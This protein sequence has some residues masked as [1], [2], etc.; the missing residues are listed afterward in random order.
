MLPRVPAGLS[1][2]T[3]WRDGIIGMPTPSARSMQLRWLQFLV[4]VL[5]LIGALVLIGLGITGHAVPAGSVNVWLIVAGGFVI[6]VDLLVM[7]SFPSATRT[8]LAIADQANGLRELRTALG[9]LQRIL[10]SIEENTRLSDTAKSVAHREQELEAL[11]TA[12]HDDYRAE[13]WEAALNLIDD[14]ERRFGT[15]EE[16]ERLREELDVARSQAIE[17]KLNDAIGNVE[18][19]FQVYAWEKAQQEIDRLILAL[20]EHA[21]VVALQDRMATLKVTHKKELLGAWEEAVRRSDTDHAIDVLKELDQYLSR[22]EAQ[23]L[24]SSARNVFKEKLLQMGVQFRFAVTE[25]RWQD[26]LS[27]GLDIVREF[28]N[29]R[30]ASEV[31]DA[32]DTLRERA[33][34]VPA[35]NAEAVQ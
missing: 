10:E 15:R 17:S 23:A 16:A 30:M 18:T 19:H 27:V 31:R 22:A 2:D 12:I 5:A 26:A 20:P 33:R 6:F 24:Q 13:A 1:L 11:R 14:M 7:T 29:A 3:Q 4:C 9:A 8:D 21:K 34:S 32:L 28:P 35:A 25:K